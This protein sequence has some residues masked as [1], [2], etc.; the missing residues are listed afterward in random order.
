[1]LPILS[2]Q[3]AYFQRAFGMPLTDIA[4]QVL[5][6]VGLM[7]AAGAFST[8]ALT[9]RLSAKYPNALAWLPGWGL[10]LC[11]PAYWLAFT[12]ES[13]PVAIGGLIVGAYVHYGYLGAQYTI[14]QGVASARSRATAV[15]LLLFVVNMIGYGLG[16]LF[17]G[18]G[19]DYFMAQMLDASSY[20]GELN[21][22]VCKGSPAELLASLGAEK[23]AACM[24]ASAGG[25]RR[26]ILVTVS[27][28]AVAGAIY[29]FTCKT[30][31]QD[32]IAK[33]S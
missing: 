21:A 3:A 32:L 12:T 22:L 26:A 11:V 29:L 13:V 16:P 30:L 17:V 27:I 6:P 18:F 23:S 4:L 20:A 25:L 10:I 31:Q 8:G 33:L 7:A 9:E 28:F 5:V 19:S 14:A 24:N 1:M 15:A 2:F